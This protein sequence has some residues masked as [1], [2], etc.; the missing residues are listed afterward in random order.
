MGGCVSSEERRG[1][2]YQVEEHPDIVPNAQNDIVIP[3]NEK[4]ANELVLTP[5]QQLDN[6]VP[7]DQESLAKRMKDV[8][9]E[10]VKI[11]QSLEAQK[12]QYIQELERELARANAQILVDQNDH[13][14]HNDASNALFH[15]KRY[16]DSLAM[17]N[18]AIF[19]APQEWVY[20]YG[21]G[22]TY[23][24]LNNQE[25]ALV[26]FN[27]G[28][29]LFQEYQGNISYKDKWLVHNAEGVVSSLIENL[30]KLSEAPLEA[31]GGAEEEMGVAT[32]LQD[33]RKELADKCTKVLDPNYKQTINQIQSTN[34]EL[35][36]NPQVAEEMLIDPVKLNADMQAK[37]PEIYH[38]QVR[39]DHAK[40]T[41]ID[42]L[43]LTINDIEGNDALYRFYQG[44]AEPW[45]TTYIAS[46]AVK[47][48]LLVVNTSNMAVNAAVSLATLLPFGAG[49]V[50]TAL[51]VVWDAHKTKELEVK[52]QKFIKITPHQSTL[53]DIVK[54][55]GL[56]ITIHYKDEIL[57]PKIEQKTKNWFSK[58][59]DGAKKLHQGITESLYGDMLPS[60]EEKLGYKCANELIS[61]IAAGEFELTKGRDTL[62]D[63]LEAALIGQDPDFD[64]VHFGFE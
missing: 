62:I 30:Q 3:Q 19:L 46:H 54:Y 5:V 7:D 20:Y 22:N 16:E 25:S 12:L 59:I 37:T 36:A 17:R 29:R 31:I 56:R 38:T 18:K 64:D 24:E 60:S 55:L 51:Q 47:S 27:E 34:S 13:K 23:I 53:D 63:R 11:E 14:A 9:L 1:E 57:S 52:A 2:G 58:F 48:G 28:Y 35:F 44:F 41:K 8:I 42:T 15:L 32:K 43:K 6:V 49:I 50:G 26:D 10:I 4:S 21:R 33:E 45:T 39:I 61:R 40:K